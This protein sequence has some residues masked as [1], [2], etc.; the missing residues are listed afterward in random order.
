MADSSVNNIH[1]EKKKLSAYHLFSTTQ[2][3]KESFAKCL[4]TLTFI[5]N[6]NKKKKD[7]LVLE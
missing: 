7:A 3:L 1:Q 4:K 6:K 2:L 5:K